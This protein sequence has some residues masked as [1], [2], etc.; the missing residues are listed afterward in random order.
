MKHTDSNANSIDK[1]FWKNPLFISI[2]IILIIV[3]SGIGIVTGLWGFHTEQG[4]TCNDALYN[5]F[6]LFIMHHSFDESPDCLVNFSRWS[7]FAVIILLLSGVVLLVAI[8]ELFKLIKIY[9]F[10]NDHIIICGLN[11]ESLQLANQLF[12]NNSKE[13]VIFIDNTPDNPLHR[14]LRNPR[15][16][17]IVG[18]PYSR[19][20]LSIAKIRKAK[21]V[22]IFTGNDVQNV[23]IAKII[24]DLI[25]QKR[26]KALDCYTLIRDKEFTN[27][28]EET[29]LFKCSTDDF[30]GYLFNLNETGIKHF[31]L[32]N[33]NR[34]FESRTEIIPNLLLIGLTENTEIVLRSLIHCTTIKG[35]Q[36]VFTVIESDQDAVTAFKKKNGYLDEFATID[37]AEDMQALA[38]KKYSSVFIGY[39]QPLKAIEAAFSIH[40][41]LL[42]ENL[43]IFI[44]YNG[45][46]T[47]ISQILEEKWK[48]K[49]EK[50]ENYTL[51]ERNIHLI[52]LIKECNAFIKLDKE[53]EKYAQKANEKYTE[54]S[55]KHPENK[56]KSIKYEDLTSHFKQSNRNQCLDNYIKFYISTGENFDFEYKG[57]PVVFKESEKPILAIMEHRRWMIEKF[58]TGWKYGDK[59][60]D[61]F[62]VNP[63]LKDWHQLDKKTQGYDSIPIEMMEL[64][65]NQLFNE[66][67]I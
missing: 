26:Q 44:F 1:P 50:Q 54:L 2:I 11:D 34:V 52:N 35:Q 45:S 32:K 21:E 43:N 7:I 23:E 63:Y 5:T 25:E 17:L 29:S 42:K 60:N 28:L 24:F 56:D 22:F 13:Q 65:T 64:I 19:T 30:N 8:P 48:D 33:V 3:F 6:Q 37:F 51:K 58:V 41:Y 14:S 9:L 39:E 38:G 20:I 59:R 66:K 15:A 18:D 49:D 67:A 31:L 62:K 16:K 40:Y 55:K 10:F 36:F 12:N 27:L 53:I 61:K 46:D 57:E 4:K 47:I